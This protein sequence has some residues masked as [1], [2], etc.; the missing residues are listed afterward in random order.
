LKKT[1]LITGGNK[2]IGLEVTRMFLDLDYNIIV[3]AREFKDF[4]FANH[5]LVKTIAFDLT[6]TDDIPE[7]VSTLGTIDVLVNNAGVMFALAYNNYSNDKIQTMLKLNLESPVKLIEEVSKCMPKDGSG[8]IVNNA[9]IAGQIGHPDIWYGI[10]KAGL[11]NATKSFSKIF[12]G[13]I[14]INAVAASPV[15]TDMLDVIPIE[16][17]E[18]FLKTVITKRFAKPQEVAKTIVWLATESPEYINGTCIDIN[19]GSFPR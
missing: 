9:S 13:K 14:V 19:N 5:P 10:T 12:D 11:I 18:A 4:E 7:L 1:V 2:G 8:R 16:R 6:K 17:R 3:V 15:E